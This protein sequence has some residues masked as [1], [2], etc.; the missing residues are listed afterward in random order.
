[1]WN[2]SSSIALNILSECQNLRH[3]SLQLSSDVDE[4]INVPASVELPLLVSL[5][6]SI[7]GCTAP[8]RDP[9]DRLLL[10]QLSNLSF[11]GWVPDSIDLNFPFPT[12]LS[13]ATKLEHVEVATTSFTRD[14]FI[15]FLHQLPP[16]LRSLGMEQYIMGTSAPAFVDDDLLDLLTP[17]RDAAS[18]DPASESGPHRHHFLFPKLNTIKCIYAAHFSDEALFRFIQARMVNSE[19]RLRQVKI[20]FFRYMENDILPRVQPFIDEFGLDISLQYTK[21]KSS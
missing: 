12:L 4:S 1:M 9:L 2:L 10:P 5:K 21:T 13:T 15:A 20:T 3:C 8:Q 17:V 7:G 19:A 11:K 14:S 18:Q 16:S 6:I